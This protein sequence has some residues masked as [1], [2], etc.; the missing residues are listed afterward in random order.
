ML[1]AAVVRP[2]DRLYICTRFTEARQSIQTGLRFGKF[3]FPHGLAR[4]PTTTMRGTSDSSSNS[5]HCLVDEMSRVWSRVIAGSA[6]LIKQRMRVVADQCERA[7]HDGL[8]TSTLRSPDR[9]IS[10]PTEILSFP[11][12]GSDKSPIG[13]QSPALVGQT[14][15]AQKVVL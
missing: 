1:G 13:L 11:L 8:L 2:C 9:N 6:G 14:I 5:E 15:I 10:D 7:L 12:N 3:G 4:A